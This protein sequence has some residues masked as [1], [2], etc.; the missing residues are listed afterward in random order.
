DIGRMPTAAEEA[1]T[2]WIDKG[3]TLVRFAGP[4]LAAAPADDPLIPVRL[5]QGERALGGA[6]SWAEPQPLDDYPEAS[7]FAGLRAPEGVLVSRQVLAE[8]SSELPSLTWASLRD[9]TPLVTAR[10]LGAGRIVLFHV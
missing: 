8:P 4:R 9:G 5:R 10:S 7:P 3:G 1:L 6:M 2:D